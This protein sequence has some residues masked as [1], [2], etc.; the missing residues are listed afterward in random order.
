MLSNFKVFTKI[1]MV[2]GLLSGVAILVTVLGIRSLSAL[3]EATDAM[4]TTATQSLRT[5]GLGTSLNALS[6]SEFDL[7]GDPSAANRE[8]VLKQIDTEKDLFARRLKVLQT[9]MTGEK[10]QRLAEIET[11]YASYEK[12]LGGT[13][14]L[15]ARYTDTQIPPDLAAVRREAQISARIA[16]ELAEKLRLFALD[17]DKEVGQ[18]SDAATAK[19]ESASLQ[20]MVIAGLGIGIGIVLAFLIGRFGIARPI[21]G[22][23]V[24]LQ[25]LARGEFDIAIPDTERRDEVGDVARTAVVFK[26][27]GI[28]KLRAEQ[29]AEELKLR[30]EA[31]KKA[32]MHGLA[33]S[34]EASVG[35]IV[36]VVSSAAAELEAAARTMTESATRTSEQSTVVA[37]ASEQ[38]SVNVQTV[39]SA[40][41]ELAT[42]VRQIGSQ[43]E[44]TA[45]MASSASTNAST[46]VDRM[47]QLSQA[48]NDIGEVIDL[49]SAIAGQTNLLALN[50]TIEAARAGEAG[51]GFAVVA[52]EVKGL[53]EQTSKATQRISEQISAIQGSTVAFGEAMSTVNGSIS[54]INSIAAIVAGAVEEQSAATAEIAVN[55]QQASAGTREVSANIETVSTAASDAGAAAGQV[56]SSAGELALQADRLKQEMARFLGNVRAA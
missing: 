12:E 28:A 45:R 31:E 13:L 56:L 49:I 29:E 53:A 10:R 22:V 55:V 25:R 46:A 4:Q 48:A 5:Q 39:A 50:A 7:T 33:D 42:S 6:R 37:A 43:V 2:L 20:M 21:A 16:Q 51:K 23:V 41:E 14:A 3:N 9:S 35:G 11:L 40:T 34:F 24:I 1:L 44:Q 17:L 47:A 18:V 38:A 54:D 19:Y 15:T 26:E 30:A 8:R 27:A 36:A 32:A 52:S